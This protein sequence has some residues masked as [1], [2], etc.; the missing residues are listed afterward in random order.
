M[1]RGQI[2]KR[3]GAWHLRFY[4]L[5]IVDGQQV[6]KRV[7]ERLA[8]VSDE[9][10]TARDLWPLADAKLAPINRGAG[11]PESGLT[12][13]EFNTQYFLP[14]IVA[15]K[16]PSTAKFYREVFSNHLQ[17]PVGHIRLRDFTTR[18]AQ[19]VLDGIRLTHQSLLRIKT[20]MSAIFSYAIR[21]G[22]I[23]GANPVRE[24]KAE[25]LRNEP[26]KYAYSLKEIQ[27]MLA[28]LGEPARTVVA[29]AAFAGLRESEIRGLQWAD[30]VGS[31]LYVRRSLW[32]RHIG[33]T[34]TAES[35]GGVPVIPLLRRILDQH[36]QGNGS[37]TWIFAGEKKHFA[38]NLDNLCRRDMKPKLGASWHGWHAFRRGL[39][40]NLFEL[41]VPAEVVQ[42]ILR[43]ANV[44]TTR[45][46][47]IV[48]E[49]KRAG[50]RAMRKLGKVVGQWATNGQR[51][52]PR[53]SGKHA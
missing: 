42:T 44:S 35:K 24:S 6:R 27:H 4:R 7:C 17:G 33:E 30:Y 37:S 48:L 10:R 50:A 38:L 28:K 41:G 36:K 8:G 32:R 45:E 31:E 19:E 23:Q 34:K 43:H 1:Q 53:K 20:G 47:Y 15:R 18:H 3:N 39:A 14:Y 26:T 5:E 49:S 29:V 52:R 2:F 40:T 9:Y 11:Q 25:G 21:L 51:V 12:L 16:K 46:H 22:F 13:S